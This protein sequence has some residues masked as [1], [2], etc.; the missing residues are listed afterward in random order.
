MYSVGNTKAASFTTTTMNAKNGNLLC[1]HPLDF[2]GTYDVPMRFLREPTIDELLKRREELDRELIDYA[3]DKTWDV[4]PSE[5]HELWSEKTLVIETLFERRM[6]GEL[7]KL[8]AENEVFLCHS[9]ADKGWVRMVHDDLKS[10]GVSCCSMK[11]K[12]KWEIRSFRRSTRPWVRQ[13][14]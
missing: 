6:F 13:R 11:T 14:R 2:V 4:D 10:R 9:S 1:W 5:I 12:S 3:I 8:S 7:G